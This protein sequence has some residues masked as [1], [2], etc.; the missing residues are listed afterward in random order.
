MEQLSSDVNREVERLSEHKKEVIEDLKHANEEFAKAQVNLDGAP[1]EQ[2]VAEAN[3]AKKVLEEQAHVIEQKLNVAG[4]K[5]NTDLEK[6]NIAREAVEAAEKKLN[7]LINLSADTD[8]A[9]KL[10][11]TVTS[12]IDDIKQ[13]EAELLAARNAYEAADVQAKTS[14]RDADELQFSA[15]EA[16]NALEKASRKFYEISDIKE[17]AEAELNDAKLRQN[18]IQEYLKELTEREQQLKLEKE[19]VT[20]DLSAL[21][22]ELDQAV[23]RSVALNQ[24]VK[25]LSDE[26]ASQQR[27]DEA[28]KNADA[29]K[30]TRMK[31]ESTL[32]DISL[33]LEKAQSDVVTSQKTLQDAKNAVNDAQVKVDASKLALEKAQAELTDAQKAQTDDR[34]MSETEAK[35][36]EKEQKNGVAEHG[37]VSSWNK[38]VKQTSDKTVHSEVK[39]KTTTVNNGNSDLPKTESVSQDGLSILGALLAGLTVWGFGFK[40]RG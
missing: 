18:D 29:A 4:E 19:R 15:R 28:V 37:D 3:N 12:S 17:Q 34:K 33:A 36:T 25:S 35:T 7:D 23:E 11:P 40:K 5:A 9:T 26:E 24:R 8:E 39:T 2:A 27:V 22:K 32:T 14:V 21:S 10:K 6:A 38:D 31:S 16:F 1:T 30:S 20:N 13:A